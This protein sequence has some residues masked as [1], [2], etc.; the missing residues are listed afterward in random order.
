[1]DQVTSP[2]EETTHRIGEMLE[3]ISETASS[4]LGSAREKIDETDRRMRA[5]VQEYPLTSFF[6]A[7]AAGYMLARLATRR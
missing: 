4:S 3:G 7:V 5:F 2:G 1:M 6:A